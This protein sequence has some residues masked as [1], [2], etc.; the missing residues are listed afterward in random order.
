MSN[1]NASFKNF[2]LKSSFLLKDRQN[3]TSK[4]FHCIFT[5]SHLMEIEFS[6]CFDM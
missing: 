3:N 2:A 1:G 6:E 5:K 4:S